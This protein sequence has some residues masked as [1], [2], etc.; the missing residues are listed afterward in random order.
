MSMTAPYGRSLATGALLALSL[1]A[2]CRQEAPASADTSTPATAPAAQRQAAPL[3]VEVFN[4]GQSAIF[5]VSSE[6]VSGAR[7]AVLID[8]QFSATDAERLVEKIKASGKRLTT[9]YISHGDPDF[10]FGL[11]TV[12][13]AFPDAQ[14]VATPQ[15]VAHIEATKDDKLKVWGLQLGAG[16]PKQLLVP[17]PL[18]GD[19]LTLEGHELKIIGL[20]GASPGRTAVWVPS[21]RAVMGGVLVDAGQHVFMADT[22]TAQ[23]HQDWLAA[24]QRIG[25]L[26]PERVIPGHYAEGA[27]QDMAAVEFTA[28]YIRAFDEEA[29]KAADSAQLIQAMHERF[30]GLEGADSL[31]LSAKV[32]KGEME[33]K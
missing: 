8:A 20:D 14:I 28:S 18:Q 3:S 27:A 31:A 25:E 9:I 5:A 32:A 13:A 33:W 22:Q 24:L 12:H 4:P 15:T 11:A 1:L 17:A 2:G 6:L 23:S 16:A 10:Y 21:I 30:P 29:A 26:R 19:V 7:D